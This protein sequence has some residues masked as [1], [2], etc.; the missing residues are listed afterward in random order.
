MQP[1]WL[2][3]HPLTRCRNGT[4]SLHLTSAKDSTPTLDLP[5]YLVHNSMLLTAPQP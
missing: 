2:A 1:F 3:N 4:Y 5:H